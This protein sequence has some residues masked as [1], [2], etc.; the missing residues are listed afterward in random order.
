M[1]QTELE[2]ELESS[3]YGL[4]L[5]VLMENDNGFDHI[6]LTK[7]QFKKV[8]DAIV[9]ESKGFDSEGMEHCTMRFGI[10]TSSK[11]PFEG[12]EDSYT[13]EY[14]DSLEKQYE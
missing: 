9:V 13:Q 1:E 5:L 11:E 3:I 7:E 12:M 8:S 14:L 4:R 6:M 2:K 10:Q